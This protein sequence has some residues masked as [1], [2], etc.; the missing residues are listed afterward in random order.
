MINWRSRGQ[1]TFAF[2]LLAALPRQCASLPGDGG[3]G[4]SGNVAGH[5][6]AGSGGDTSAGEAGRSGAA[7]DTNTAGEAGSGPAAGGAAGE[8]NPAGGEGGEG[9]APDL[10][11]RVTEPLLG[12]NPGTSGK[13]T[14]GTFEILPSPPTDIADD[15]VRWVTDWSGDG[16]SA[17]G[18]YTTASDGDGHGVITFQ[19]KTGRG[20]SVENKIRIEEAGFQEMPSAL[21]SCDGSVI[22]IREGDG[23]VYVEGASIPPVEQQPT[24]LNHDKLLL[25][26]DGSSLTFLTGGD[27]IR[28]WTEWHST[29]G[30]V[31]SVL[32]DSVDSLSADGLTAFGISGCYYV[33]C[34][35]PAIFRW[36]PPW[37][38]Q[39]T[40]TGAPTTIVAA[41]G[42][43]IVYG[44][45]TSFIGIW[46]EEATQSI[47][48]GKPCE[49]VAWSSRAQVLLVN[50]ED[51]YLLWTKV[52]GLRP[53]ESLLTL[54][55][56]WQLIPTNLS[57][58]GWTVTGTAT[59]D[60]VS[61]PYF[62]AT[63]NANAFK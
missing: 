6:V 1:Y 26:E 34:N 61:Y 57:L 33:T 29:K 60:Y 15:P 58:D 11:D 16:A 35:P 62:R 7:G 56:G 30:P 12:C 18:Y 53:L 48:C 24:V 5:S 31:S 9:G 46:R 8:G 40:T 51:G 36:R 21:S 2:G 37:S 14:P 13:A 52:H 47:S 44:F 17:V 43:S 59:T 28:P 38:F 27:I 39:D 41:D 22:A 25:S 54:P 42:E 32:L 45:N 23:T 49:P 55:P 19:W 3:G 4:G 20:F 10:P 50:T 63:L